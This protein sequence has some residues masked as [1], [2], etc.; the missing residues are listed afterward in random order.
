MY[1]KKVQKVLHR[2]IGETVEIQIQSRT[3]HLYIR[4]LRSGSGTEGATPE[5]MEHTIVAIDKDAIETQNGN[6]RT[7]YYFSEVAEVVLP[8]DV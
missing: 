1:N 7:C 8:D 4:P 3:S 2:L 6:G 5:K